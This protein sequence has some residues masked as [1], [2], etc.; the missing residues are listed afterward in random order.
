MLPPEVTR[1]IKRF[2]I[3]A[4]RL[5]SAGLAGQYRSRVRG[6]GVEFDEVRLYTPGDDVRL[7]DWN[8]SARLDAPYIKKHVEERE[9]TILLAVD[10]S[11]SG[12]LGTRRQ[13]KRELA[14]E[15]CCV[16]G[17]AAALN[18]DRV[19]LLLFTDRV[20]R[21]VPP[22]TGTRHALRLV[23]DLLCYR[24]A[25]RRTQVSA[26]LDYLNRVARR[27]AVVFLVSDFISP[28]YERSL[29][30]ASR[31]H[32]LVALVISDAREREVPR[33]GLVEVADAETGERAWIDTSEAAFRQSFAARRAAENAGRVELFRRSR[34][35]YIELET[36][37]AYEARLRR[38]FAAR[39][40]RR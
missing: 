2:E 14:A 21:F 37:E 36:G 12:E 28:P 33:V 25:G 4:R 6:R 31:R 5:I 22:A 23:R 10:L 18:R 34:V 11:A 30:V 16:L 32:D 38:F 13:T 39:A 24:P 8:V 9:Q 27:P 19:G 35:D 3:R 1:R 17:L 20:E 15:V 29:R 26:A 40:E 7:I